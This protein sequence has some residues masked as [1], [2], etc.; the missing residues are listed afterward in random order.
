[1]SVKSF[2]RTPASD[3]CI[4]DCVV[5]VA[6]VGEFGKRLGNE[7]AHLLRPDYIL[8]GLDLY[9]GRAVAAFEHSADGGFHILRLLFE[10]RG[11]SK[12][13]RGGGD[14]AERIGESGA[15]DIGR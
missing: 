7:R 4:L 11:V 9:I 14:G 2:Y 10:L 8:S 3:I 15:S 13:E 6:H 1:M 5:G 12:Q